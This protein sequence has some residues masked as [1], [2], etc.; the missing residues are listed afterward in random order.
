MTLREFDMNTAY[1]PCLGMTRLERYERARK[2]GLK[3]PPKIG[4]I[5]K[6]FNVDKE[7][8]L[9]DRLGFFEKKF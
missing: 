1:G 5:L 3:P 4:M 9:H 2:W 7:C 8:L 6:A